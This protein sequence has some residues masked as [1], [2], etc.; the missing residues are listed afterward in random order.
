LTHHK[1]PIVNF[2]ALSTK[3]ARRVNLHFSRYQSRRS[4][5]NGFT[6]RYITTTTW[7][8]T[9]L[10]TSVTRTT[11]NWQLIWQLRRLQNTHW[12]TQ[13]L[14]LLTTSSNILLTSDIL[15]HIFLLCITKT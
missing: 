7:K 9:R 6:N 3:H 13:K 4:S 12:T 2:V 1:N 11:I 5:M 8:N 10:H 14:L 15:H